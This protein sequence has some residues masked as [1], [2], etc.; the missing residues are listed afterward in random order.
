[1]IL[2]AFLCAVLYVHDGDTLRCTDGTRIRIAGIDA[3][4]TDGRCARGHPCASAPPEQATAQLR[5]LTTGQ[6]LTCQP[7]G[8]T[9]N[10]IAAFCRTSNGTD[11]SCAMLASGTVAKWDR[12]WRNHRC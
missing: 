10:R 4:E 8:T 6:T 2:A 5:R 7:N 1:M 11:I 9:Y 3:K 12:Y